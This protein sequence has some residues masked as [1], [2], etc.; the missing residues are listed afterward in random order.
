MEV[1]ENDETW[2]W[3]D[4]DPDTL[5]STE[6]HV[7]IVDDEITITAVFDLRYTTRIEAG[8]NIAKTVFVCI[9]LTLGAIFFTK[10]AN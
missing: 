3:E 5:R 2:K 6:K 4:T 8:L 10:D 7:A 1:E 9:V